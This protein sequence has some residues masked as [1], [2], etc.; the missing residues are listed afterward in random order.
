MNGA[1]WGMAW[2]DGQTGRGKFA[3]RPRASKIEGTSGVVVGQVFELTWR[4]VAKGQV[5][6]LTY[7]L[8]R[9]GRRGRG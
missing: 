6:D 7:L 3:G 2:Q 1:R 9:A 4:P 5:K 8:L